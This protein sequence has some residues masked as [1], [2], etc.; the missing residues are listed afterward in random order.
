MKPQRT[1]KSRFPRPRIRSP[2]HPLP[3]NFF[4]RHLSNILA[5][6]PDLAIAPTN[7]KPSPAAPDVA[8]SSPSLPSDNTPYHPAT[9]WVDA[10]VTLV[11]ALTLL[12][13]VAWAAGVNA[14]L[15][16]PGVVLVGLVL[17]AMVVWMD[18][19]FIRLQ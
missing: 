16:L 9:N 13:L 8:A 15:V 3:K 4:P 6:R 19:G 7:P 10:S 14:L 1:N 2:R 12:G 5:N 18:G 17:I 11:V